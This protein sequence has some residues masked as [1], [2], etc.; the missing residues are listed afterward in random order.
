MKGVVFTEFFEMVE[1]LFGYEMVDYLIEQT[2]LPSKGIY[3]AV[4]TY[5]HVEIVSL[6]TT[7]HKKS[8]IPVS[9]LLEKFGHYLYGTFSSNYPHLVDGANTAFDML[10]S[11]EDYIHVEVRKL[12]PDAQLPHFEIKDKSDNHLTMI[13]RSDRKMADLAFGLITACLESFDTKADVKMTVEDEEGKQV[14]FTID[15][16]D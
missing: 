4:G 10:A 2:D 1:G 14:R 6:V 8:E 5:D 11:I 7:L 16:I 12:Y 15:K 3:T 9:T 13:Y